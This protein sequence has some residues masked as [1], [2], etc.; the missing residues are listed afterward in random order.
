MKSLTLSGLLTA[1][2]L[3]LSLLTAG[4]AS[5]G[6][7][8]LKCQNGFQKVGTYPNS[9]ECKRFKGGFSTHKA[10]KKAAKRWKK[11]ASCNAHMSVPQKQV[12][13]KTTNSWAARVTFICANI[14]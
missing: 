12:W 7:A 4:M 5:A 3:A 13:Q 1:G 9:I 10:A 6:T 2:M 8:N 14:T 11:K